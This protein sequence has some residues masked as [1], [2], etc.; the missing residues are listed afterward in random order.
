MAL[1]SKYTRFLALAVIAV[2]GDEYGPVNK[3][4]VPCESQHLESPG[5]LQVEGENA[6]T[7]DSHANPKSM[8]VSKIRKDFAVLGREI[9]GKLPIYFDSACQTL[10]PKPVMDAMTEYYESFPS[11]AGRSVHKLATEV[12]LRCDAARSRVADFFDAESPTEIAFLKNTTEGLNTVIFGMGLKKGDEIVT[13]DYEHNSVHVPVVQLTKTVGVRHRMVESAT[14]GTFDLERF[15]KAMNKKVRLVAMCLTSNVS[16]YT[17]PARGVVEIAH[18]YG[19]KVL[20]D[21]AQ[22]APSMKIDVRQLGVDFMAA[23]AHKM[24]GPSG[25]GVFYARAE[26]SDRLT[27]LMFGGHGVTDTDYASFKLLPAPERFETGLQNYSGIVGTGAALDYLSAIGMDAIREHEI[28]LNKRMTRALVDVPG[29]SVIKPTDPNMRGGIF[30]FNIRGLSAHDI[31]M[32]LDNSNNIMMRSGMHCCHT[33]FHSRGIDGCARA[34]VYIYNEE[35]EVD[36]FTEA[37]SDLA[38]KFG[39]SS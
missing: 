39:K 7:N 10:R 35:E 23:S 28:S 20:F 30:S 4:A 19:A 5:L 36:V 24:C 18:S 1:W 14:D 31:A 9:G 16:G 21:A 6:N 32:I 8:D 29:V 25:V 33:Y 15:E 12:S 3:F 34:S 26:I 38:A 27:P 17:L 11:C 22:A 37:V 13:T 2:Q